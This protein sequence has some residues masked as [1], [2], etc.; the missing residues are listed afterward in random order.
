MLACVTIEYVAGAVVVLKLLLTSIGLSEE[1]FNLGE[2][3]RQ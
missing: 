1:G 3:L 2:S